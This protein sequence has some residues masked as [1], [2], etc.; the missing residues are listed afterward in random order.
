MLAP[1]FRPGRILRGA[2]VELR[3]P[4]GLLCI[5]IVSADDKKCTHHHTIV[6]A[7]LSTGESHFFILK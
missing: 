7:A 5:I 6:K 3:G 1:E 4:C 2:G